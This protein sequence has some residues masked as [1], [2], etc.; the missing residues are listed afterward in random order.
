MIYRVSFHTRHF[1]FEAHDTDKDAAIAAM[2]R[3]LRKHAEQYGLTSGWWH[4]EYPEQTPL[5]EIFEVSSF[6]PGVA[7]RDRSALK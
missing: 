1:D 6:E 2:T 3:G 7:Y 4:E 5:D